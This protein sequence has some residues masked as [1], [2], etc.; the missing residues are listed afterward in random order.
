MLDL[1]NKVDLVITLGGDGTV[2]WVTS[3]LRSCTAISTPVDL[4]L[5]S[6]LHMHVVQYL[7]SILNLLLAQ[8]QL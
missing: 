8:E 1:H 2:L 6:I 5:H 3:S 7:S 4:I